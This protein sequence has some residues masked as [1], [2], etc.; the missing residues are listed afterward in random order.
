MVPLTRHSLSLAVSRL[1]SQVTKR[2]LGVE[3]TRDGVKSVT[4]RANAA[5]AGD[6]EA[7]TPSYY[8]IEYAT[9]SS[10]GTKIFCCKYCIANRKLYVLQAQA[11]L[12]AFDSDANVKRDLRGVV[13]SFQVQ[14]K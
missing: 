3:E 13:S 6:A 11:N 10:R 4:L 9:V 14:S 2:V 12:D 1:A 7:G 8:T 5:E